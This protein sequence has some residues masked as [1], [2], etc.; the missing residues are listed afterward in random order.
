MERRTWIQ[1]VSLSAAAV[2]GFNLSAGAQPNSLSL[3][4]PR[5]RGNR[6]GIIS[7][8]FR[9][10]SENNWQ[11]ALHQVSA[12][13]YHFLEGGPPKDV[14]PKIFAREVQAAGLTSICLGGA[15]AGLQ[16]DLDPVL[17]SAEALQ[18]QYIICYWPWLSG[19]DNIDLSEAEL[20][21]DNLNELGKKI[22][23]AGF[24]L[25]WHNHDKEFA[26]LGE[27]TVFDYLMAQTDPELVAVQLDWYW[28]V[29]GN[30]D[31][32]DLLRRYPG[33]M[34]LAHVKDMNNN[35]DRGMTCAGSGIIDFAS[36][37]PEAEAMGTQYLIVENERAIDGIRCARGSIHHLKTL[38]PA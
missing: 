28:V 38:L 35:R 15:M 10:A 34:E 21:A 33:R 32:I 20:A 18:S 23:Q 37:L 36:I 16:K 24:R 6:L 14:D 29:K 2:A 4:V 7:N 31:V 22:K 25:A 27:E 19:A 9:D 8:T 26:A 12:L 13:G 11:R 30:A 1:K 5:F 17:R 3:Y